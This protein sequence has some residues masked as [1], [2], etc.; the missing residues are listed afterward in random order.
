MKACPVCNHEHREAIEHAMFMMTPEN[1]SL[2]IESVA[3][4]FDVAIED[5]Q[6][7]MLFHSPYGTPKS[8]DSIVRRVKMQEVDLLG[9]T[10]LEYASTLRSVGARVRGMMSDPEDPKAFEKRLSKSITDLY[11]GCGDTLQKTVRAMADIDNLLNGPKDDG[12]S[13]LAAL[14]QALQ[15]SKPQESQEPVQETGVDVGD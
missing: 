3:E 10:A 8:S 7:H 14:A 6:R 11:L 4:E 12:V 2:S 5:L 9:E 13:G 15:R 1:A